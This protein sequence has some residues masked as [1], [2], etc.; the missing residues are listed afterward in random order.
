MVPC[1]LSSQL[2]ASHLDPSS[3]YSAP[4]IQC[5]YKCPHARRHPRT[6]IGTQ[7]KE[8][9]VAGWPDT[10]IVSGVGGV[11]WGLVAGI[12]EWIVGVVPP[13]G[14]PPGGVPSGGVSPEGSLKPDKLT[15]T[16]NKRPTKRM[17]GGLFFD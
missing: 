2:A 1:G 12:V 15:T 9:T 10:F 14:V 8:A 7:Q 13:G 16:T 11:V 3:P 17:Y 5:A 4:Q 6:R